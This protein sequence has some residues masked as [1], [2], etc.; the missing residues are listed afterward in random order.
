MKPF[1]SQISLQ[2]NVYSRFWIR[3]VITSEIWL[4]MK[5]NGKLVFF[6]QARSIKNNKI[7]VFYFK[8]SAVIATLCSNPAI[9]SFIT[10]FC[11]LNKSCAMG[12]DKILPYSCQHSLVGL[13]VVYPPRQKLFVLLLL[14]L[15]QYI[16]I[17]SV[18][19]G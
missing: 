1:V 11:F 4:K 3:Q 8:S 16:V 19:N 5:K 14:W 9:H 17:I 10:K 18:W 2:K 12:E 7:I 13:H 15:C 6:L